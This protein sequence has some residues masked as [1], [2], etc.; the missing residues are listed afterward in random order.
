MAH[1]IPPSSATQ[2]GSSTCYQKT[3]HLFSQ[4]GKSTTVKRIA[5]F[6]LSMIPIYFMSEKTPFLNLCMAGGVSI[7][8]GGVHYIR[9]NTLKKN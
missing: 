1:S 8:V 5:L 9:G 2:T 3:S 7:V 4:A 6:C